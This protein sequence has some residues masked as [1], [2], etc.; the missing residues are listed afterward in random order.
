MHKLLDELSHSHCKSLASATEAMVA[1]VAMAAL[2]VMEGKVEKD[3]AVTETVL[4]LFL[5]PPCSNSLRPL[6][7]GM[8]RA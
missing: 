4:A 1:M 7:K 6:S 8:Q 3:L 5:P 2:A